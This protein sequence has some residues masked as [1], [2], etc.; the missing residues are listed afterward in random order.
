MQ[1]QQSGINERDLSRVTNQARKL[2]IS[3]PCPLFYLKKCKL[4]SSEMGCTLLT[5]R[6]KGA[7]K[8]VLPCPSDCKNT[9]HHKTS[10]F[11]KS[12]IFLSN[13]QLK[14]R[15]CLPCLSRVSCCRQRR[16]IS[17]SI[18]KTSPLPFPQEK[19]LVRRTIFFLILLYLQLTCNAEFVS[20]RK[21]LLGLTGYAWSQ[22]CNTAF[23]IFKLG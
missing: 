19:K 11:Q 16:L 14:L 7:R 17:H 4:F 18:V 21:P 2:T 20:R 5:L 22:I 13:R 1:R 12:V 23:P 8:M 9:A 15:R 6:L 10:Y 3:S